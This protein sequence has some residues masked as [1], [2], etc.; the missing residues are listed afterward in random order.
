M[1]RAPSR[2]IRD[3]LDDKID[4]AWFRIC[5]ERMRVKVPEHQRQRALNPDSDTTAPISSGNHAVDSQ[6][7]NQLTTVNMTIWEMVGIYK[8]AGSVHHF[9]PENQM[10]VYEAMRDYLV[11]WADRSHKYP[12]DPQPAMTDFILMDEFVESE[13][14]E[15]EMNCL[16]TRKPV[17]K[18][19]PRGIGA[20]MRSTFNRAGNVAVAAPVFAP[21]R[22]ESIIKRFH[23]NV[24]GIPNDL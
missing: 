5:N 4:A 7:L 19:A 23:E 22:Y 3:E 20:Q 15:Y 1:A 13:H 16:I 24:W 9:K 8:H 12:D 10:V 21:T 6:L 17:V 2:K 11:M 14:P 18:A